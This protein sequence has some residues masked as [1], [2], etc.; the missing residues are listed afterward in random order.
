MKIRSYGKTE[1]ALLYNPHLST[2]HARRKLMHWIS[3]SPTLTQRL[4][5]LGYHPSDR[6]FSPPQVQAIV[7]ELLEP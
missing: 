3:I 1:L 2:Q 6:I 7:D 4:Q 5:S